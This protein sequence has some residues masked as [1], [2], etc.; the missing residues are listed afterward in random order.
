MAA[1]QSIQSNWQTT[2]CNSGRHTSI[3]VRTGAVLIFSAP[4]VLG[5]VVLEVDA[6]GAL[7]SAML[8]TVRSTT[9]SFAVSKPRS[10]ASPTLAHESLKKPSVSKR[11]LLRTDSTNRK[12]QD[13]AA[14]ASTSSVIQWRIRPPT[15]I[16]TTF[17]CLAVRL[18][19][20]STSC[21]STRISLAT[22]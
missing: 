12:W 5:V 17:V 16:N 10:H 19:S 2:D 1:R 8:W 14:S 9:R 4:T 21:C 6:A 18:R 20:T 3:P 22:M 7:R 13:S 15:S 11:F